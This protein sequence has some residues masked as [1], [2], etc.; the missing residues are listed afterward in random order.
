MMRPADLHRPPTAMPTPGRFA[1]ANPLEAPRVCP[2]PPL[3]SVAAAVRDGH[4]R[5]ARA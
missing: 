4:P 1:M 2:P 3:T 5:R